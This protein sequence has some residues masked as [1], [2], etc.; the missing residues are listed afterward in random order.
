L[1]HCGSVALHTRPL[2]AVGVTPN[3]AVSSAS[4]TRKVARLPGKPGVALASS[5]GAAVTVSRTVTELVAQ[6]DDLLASR[7]GISRRAVALSVT[8]TKTPLRAVARAEC[9]GQSTIRTTIA[10]AADACVVAIDLLALAVS[11]AVVWATDDRCSRCAFGSR[12]ASV[13]IARSTDA[14]SVAGTVI[15]AGTTHNVAGI[16]TESVLT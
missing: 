7:A 2:V 4:V 1:T 5:V 13:T 9:G 15:W 6:T 10:V 3:R 12:K 11:R 14:D 16:T 8:R